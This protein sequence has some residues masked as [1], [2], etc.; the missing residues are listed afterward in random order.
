MKTNLTISLILL[1]MCVFFHEVSAQSK[2]STVEKGY[3]RGFFAEPS[4]G[5]RFNCGSKRAN[6]GIS[7]AFDGEIDRTT[8]AYRMRYF[9]Q[10]RIKFGVEF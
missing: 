4:V 1:T 3:Y 6:M 7:Y 10:V 9:P 8:D 5:V 2:D